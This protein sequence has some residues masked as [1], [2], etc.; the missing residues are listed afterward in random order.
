MPRNDQKGAILM[1]IASKML[2]LG[3]KLSKQVQILILGQYFLGVFESL[4]V[5]ERVFRSRNYNRTFRTVF[6]FDNFGFSNPCSE[7]L[8]PFS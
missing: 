5:F 7:P 1:K 6:R 2:F 4:S 8:N 3:Q